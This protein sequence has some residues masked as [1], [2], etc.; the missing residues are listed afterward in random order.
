MCIDTIYIYVCVCVWLSIYLSINLLQRIGLCDWLAKKSPKI[1]RAGSQNGNIIFRLKPTG[2][3]CSSHPQRQLFLPW[4]NLSLPSGLPSHR[5]GH[6]PFPS[7]TQ[8]I[9]D[10]LPY[11]K[12]AV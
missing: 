6:S 9:Q 12:A 5:F 4:G 8:F 3:G 2:M 10:K 1:G 11:F 7:P